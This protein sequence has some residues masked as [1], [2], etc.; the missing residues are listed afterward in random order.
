M[1]Q[2]IC[3]SSVEGKKIT[4]SNLKNHTEKE[5]TVIRER[6]NQ[7][8]TNFFFIGTHIHLTTYVLIFQMKG[9]NKRTL[10]EPILM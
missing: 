8:I 1:L 2:N 4:K 5:T 6:K 3:K 9:K 10:N 7:I